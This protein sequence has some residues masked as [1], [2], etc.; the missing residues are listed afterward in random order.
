M[1]EKFHV[2]KEELMRDCCGLSIVAL[3]ALTTW[4]QS[5]DSQTPLAELTRAWLSY[6]TPDFWE[7][8]VSKIELLP[9]DDGNKAARELNYIAQMTRAVAEFKSVLCRLS[10]GLPSEIVRPDNLSVVYAFDEPH[11]LSRFDYH[12]KTR[13]TKFDYLRRSFRIFPERAGIMAVLTDTN[14]QIAAIAPPS[15]KDVSLRATEP[16]VKLFPPYWQL[17]TIDVWPACRGP[18]TVGQVEQ[19]STYS[20]FGRPAFYAIAQSEYGAQTLLTVLKAKLVLDPTLGKI[21]RED[22]LAVIGTRTSLH[23]TASCQ[24]SHALSASHMRMIVGISEDRE[25]V[26]TFQPPEPA[27]AHAAMLILNQLGWAPFLQHLKSAIGATY[28]DAGYRGELMAQIILLMASDQTVQELNGLNR[29]NDNTDLPAVPLFNLLTKLLGADKAA[30]LKIKAADKYVRLTQFCQLLS[31]PPTRKL[32]DLWKRSTGFVCMGNNPGCDIVIPVLCIKPGEILQDV[33][34]EAERMSVLAIQV[35][36]LSNQISAREREALCSSKMKR[37]Q[38]CQ[39]LDQKLPFFCGLLELRGEPSAV[40]YPRRGIQQSFAIAGLKPS[41]VMDVYDHQRQELDNSFEELERARFDPKTNPE[42][43]HL[44]PEARE[45][46]E[47][48]FEMNFELAYD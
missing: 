25:S 17:N 31:L 27:L 3:Q 33:V 29:L 32:A 20:M 11:Q 2:S 23:V 26:Y 14:S 34:V 44:Y 22:A 12:A 16:G 10:V 28:A 38:C 1:F 18:L 41:D 6:Q 36:C 43:D 24:A 35:K 46:V 4:L 8:V 30:P 37:S 42:H 47:K 21:T 45:A 48:A 7:T 5:Q 9:V 13:M 15:S 39:G 19:L 40:V